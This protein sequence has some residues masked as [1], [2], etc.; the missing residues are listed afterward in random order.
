MILVMTPSV[1]TWKP[2][3]KVQHFRQTT[4]WFKIY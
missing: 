2:T 1:S 3:A 4:K